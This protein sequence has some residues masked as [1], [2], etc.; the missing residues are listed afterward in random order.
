MKILHTSDLHLG[1]TWSG[2]SRLQDQTRV[3]DE[4]LDLCEQHD[5]DLLLVTGDVF[6]D[7]VEGS[8]A[9]VARRF[10]E[11]LRRHLAHDRA[12]FL[13]RGNH[14]HFA[15]FQLLRTLVNELAGEDRWPLIIADIPGIYGIPGHQLQVLAL[16]YMTPSWIEQNPPEIDVTPEQRLTGLTGTLA[17][18]VQWL[19]Q[20]VA[21]DIPAI[22]AGHVLISGAAYNPE[23]EVEMGYARDLVL[24]AK[25]LPHFT[26][27]NAL[28]HIH[29][30]QKVRHTVKPTWYA[31]GPDRLD[32]GEQDYQPRVL[33]V[34]T[35]DHPGGEAAVQEIPLTSCT[36]FLR[37]ELRGMDAVQAFCGQV[38]SPDPLGMLTLSDIPVEARRTVEDQLRQVAPR[39]RILWA[40]PP[41]PVAIDKPGEESNFHNITETVNA[42][43]VKVFKLQPERLERLQEAFQS[44]WSDP[45]EEAGR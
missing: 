21:P 36:P 30:A 10:L 7:R 13:L 22:F 44:L 31:G 8:L 28:G 2:Q 14:D 17:G 18:Y 15:F 35:P 4:V 5:V 16:P 26:S 9:A 42:Y 12:V 23:K 25:N 19:G 39:I 3:L 43:L 27:Y 40:Q 33:L 6:A 11:Q 37:E 20:Q 1:M 29:L 34:T 41:T 32:L 38:K 24:E 45:A